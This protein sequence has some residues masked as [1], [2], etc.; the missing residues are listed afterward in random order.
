MTS[1]VPTMSIGERRIG[2]G[3]PVFVIAEIGATHAGDVEL[4]LKLIDAAA[5]AGA[6]AVKLQTVNP[7]FSYAK[8]TLSHDIFQTLQLS[9]D[10]MMRMKRAAEAAGLLMFSTPGDFPSLE[11]IE[12]LDLPLMKVSSG[13]MTNKPLV[14]A[15]VGTGKPVIISSG[16]AYLDEIARSVRFAQAAGARELA[17][18]H[19]TSLYPC[20]DEL[21]NL[22]AI[23]ALGQALGVPVGFSDHSP[24]SLACIGAVALGASVLEKHMA[25]SHE[26]AGPEKGTACDVEEFAEMVRS[27]RRMK[28][29]RGAGTKAPADEEGEGRILHRRT[30]VACAAIPA[31]AE[32]TRQNISVMRG[33]KEHIGLSPEAFDDILGNVAARDIAENEPIKIGMV[34]EAAI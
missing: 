25:L 12:R 34:A 7:D 30:V 2:A 6:D 16:M 10:E 18:L 13:L 1:N 27:I 14:Q 11:L 29:M 17:V 21:L 8:G 20:P 28:A 4:A 32:F 33:A 5:G 9:F 23:E 31:G 3:Q 22:R 24:D 15:V 26:L 19:C